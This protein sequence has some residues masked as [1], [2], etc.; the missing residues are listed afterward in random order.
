M[1]PTRYL[2]KGPPTAI[3]VWSEP[4]G[5]DASL[6]FCGLVAPGRPIPE[7]LP[8]E[9][10]LVAGWLAFKLIEPAPA[11]AAPAA[12][13]PAVPT[14]PTPDGRRRRANEESVDG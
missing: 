10:A 4:Y 13:A 2:W 1:T 12:P 11:E 6:I 8:A 7:M 3:E 14:P 5:P 9:H